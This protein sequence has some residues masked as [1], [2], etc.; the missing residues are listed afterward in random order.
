MAL[1]DTAVDL[2][3]HQI[4]ASLFALQSPLSQ[5]VILADEV[6]LRKTIEA[7]I[8]L[9]QL[10][11][12]RKRRLLVISVRQCGQQSRSPAAAAVSLLQADPPQRGDGV[13]PVHGAAPDHA[14]IQTDG[15]RTCAV[16]GSFQLSPAG[17][18]YAL[19]QRQSHLTTL[20]LQKLLTSSSQA[21]AD[22]STMRT[23]WDMEKNEMQKRHVLLQ[24][25]RDSYVG[26]MLNA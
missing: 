8:V 24:E 23:L 25:D 16:R 7:G 10:W 20:I 15:Q 14:A 26:M 22:T 1:F 4:E 11:A 19:P 17:H 21:I 12:E 13:H 6:G 5:G 3:P 2:N 9:C 18:S